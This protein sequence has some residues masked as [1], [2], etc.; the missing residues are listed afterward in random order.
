MITGL[1]CS[2]NP[3]KM[4]PLYFA[5]YP[6]PFVNHLN[7]DLYTY[8]ENRVMLQF[9]DPLGNLLFDKNLNTGSQTKLQLDMT[10]FQPGV[11]FIRMVMGRGQ[12]HQT[13]K[14]LKSY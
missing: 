9:Y 12:E 5:A 13:L 14:V 6:N 3:L 11:Y 1:H 4:Q 2:L 10:R 7:L 8:P